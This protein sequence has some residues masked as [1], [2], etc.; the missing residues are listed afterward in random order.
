VKSNWTGWGIK[1]LSLNG[2]EE[3]DL[4]H[5]KDKNAKEMKLDGMTLQIEYEIEYTNPNSGVVE[6]ISPY[7]ISGDYFEIWQPS[8]KK[9]TVMLEKNLTGKERIIK[10]HVGDGNYFGSIDIIQSGTVQ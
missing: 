9:L 8:E 3:L 5:E 2:G 6:Y 1:G 10:I 4:F 7:R